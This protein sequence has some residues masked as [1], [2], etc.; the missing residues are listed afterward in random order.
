MN[1]IPLRRNNEAE[2]LAFDKTC[3][4]LAGFDPRL[5]FEWVDGLLCSLAA[6]PRVPPAAEWLPAFFGDTFERTFADPEDHARALRALQARL[7]VLCSQLDPEW[8]FEDPDALRLDPLLAEWS[9]EDRRRLVEEGGL[10]PSA[11]LQT[12]QEWAGAFLTGVDAMAEL[13]TGPDDEEAAAAFGAAFA[14]VKALIYP[15]DSDELKAHLATYY[16][17]REHPTQEDLLAEA[18][19]SVQDMRMYWVD[20]APVPPTRRVEPTPGRNEPC[21]CGS[22]KKYKKCHGAAT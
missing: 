12:G 4:R 5:H 2:L 9:E 3:E 17:D 15:P 8:L 16:K 19:M 18:C 13:W 20:F 22:G 14:Q 11:L 21:P 1:P 6:A 7:A 10:E